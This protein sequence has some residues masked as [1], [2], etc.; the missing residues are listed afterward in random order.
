MYR[1]REGDVANCHYSY[2]SIPAVGNA[3]I[4]SRHSN[5][6]IDSVF[7]HFT[8]ALDLVNVTFH[9]TSALDRMKLD[10]VLRSPQK[11]SAR[12]PAV[13]IRVRSRYANAIRASNIYFQSRGLEITKAAGVPAF[14]CFRSISCCTAST[15]HCQ[16]LYERKKSKALCSL[17]LLHV[18]H[19]FFSLSLIHKITPDIDEEQIPIRWFVMRITTIVWYV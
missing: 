19:T 11:I 1:E 6:R 15:K 3:K 16:I 5:S 4:T 12:F 17:F 18:I 10:G 7:L 14:E 9:Y 2:F 8:F 13:I